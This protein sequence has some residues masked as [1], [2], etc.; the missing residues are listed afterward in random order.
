MSRLFI[1]AD[2]H[3]LYSVWQKL[4]AKLLPDDV[5]VIAGDF[6][7]NRF[8]VLG[9]PDYQPETLRAEFQALPNR[10]YYVY[11]NCDIPEFFPNQE[12]G[13]SFLYED[14]LIFVYH[15]DA[16]PPQEKYDIVI[17]GHTH[18]SEI[19]KSGDTLYINPGSPSR[20]HDGTA[21]YAIYQNGKAEIV[22]I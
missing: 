14:K 15:G 16:S 2:I 1:T 7:G 12:Y 17:S 8:P 18:I 4:L 22:E 9:N 21:S 11:G 20:P 5:L 10:K 3:G 13:L 19:R 6:F